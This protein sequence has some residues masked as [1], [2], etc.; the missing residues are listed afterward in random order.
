MSKEEENKKFSGLMVF[1]GILGMLITIG[2]VML[3]G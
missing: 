3:F 2:L 1:I